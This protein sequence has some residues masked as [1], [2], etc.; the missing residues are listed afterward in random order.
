MLHAQ[1]LIIRRNGKRIVGDVSLSV[2]GGE[3]VALLG[4]SNAGKSTLLRAL[5]GDVVPSAGTAWLGGKR[6]GEWSARELATRRAVLPQHASLNYPLS[7]FDVVLTGR[8]PHMTVAASKQD[9]AVAEAALAWADASHLRPRLY[10]S[11]S[12]GEQQQVQLAR[13]LAQVWGQARRGDCYVFLDEPT[14]GLDPLHQHRTMSVAKQLAAD[15]AAVLLIMHDINLAAQYC[16]R[17]MMM[18]SGRLLHEGKP[19]DVLTP[20]TIAEVFRVETQVSA[21]PTLPCPWVVPTAAMR[22]ERAPALGHGAVT[23]PVVDQV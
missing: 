2:I 6:V 10:P 5:C 18:R 21:H 8:A 22:K 12:G 15:G 9:Y 3:I 7:A 17:L 16:D 19:H 1:E 4:P 13:V 14:Q 20:D 11:L 23:D